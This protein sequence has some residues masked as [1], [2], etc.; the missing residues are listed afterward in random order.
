MPYFILCHPKKPNAPIP[1]SAILNL[2]AGENDA[3]DASL[4]A[5]GAHLGV[6]KG[7]W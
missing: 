5:W 6:G 3:V 7:H 2:E 1:D 4:V